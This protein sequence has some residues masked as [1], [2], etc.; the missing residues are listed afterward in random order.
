VRDSCGGSK[1]EVWLFSLPAQSATKYTHL[2]RSSTT[3][4]V[5]SSGAGISGESVKYM[6]SLKQEQAEKVREKMTGLGSEWRI[7]AVRTQ[8]AFGVRRT[9]SSV[10][11]TI[12]KSDHRRK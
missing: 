8:A 1:A 6:V 11:P 2:R 10:S 12:M 3:A 4:N 7:P 9:C 5:P